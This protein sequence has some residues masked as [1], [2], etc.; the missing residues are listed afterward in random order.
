MRVHVF[1]HA[2]QLTRIVGIS[3]QES[4]GAFGKLAKRFLHVGAQDTVS[5]VV[6]LVHG[7]HY[8][9]GLRSSNID[10]SSRPWCDL[11]HPHADRGLA[12][13]QFGRLL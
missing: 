5:E 10:S 7:F 9:A 4:A 3:D 11:P 8:L 13:A 1:H 2:R 12:L 6:G